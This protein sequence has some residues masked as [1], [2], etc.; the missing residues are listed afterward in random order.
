MGHVI[1]VEMY[2]SVWLTYSPSVL[3]PAL[4][5]AGPSEQCHSETHPLPPSLSRQII[6]RLDQAL[7]INDT[8]QI[9]SAWLNAGPWSCLISP[10]LHWLH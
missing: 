2:C 7:L 10:T 9:E 4:L 5:T 3:S 8:K 6:E 1:R